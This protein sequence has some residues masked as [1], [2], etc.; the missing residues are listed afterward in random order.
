MA[1]G[2]VLVADDDAAIRVVLNQA[3]SRAG[4]EVRVTSNVSTLWQWVQEG[5]GDCVIS[6]VIMPDGDAFEFMPGIRRERPDLPVIL[7]SAQNTFMTAVK[8]Q[9]AGAYEY[10]PKP[11]DLDELITVTSRAIA[12]PK[13]NRSTQRPE[14]YA[15][16]MPL[17]GRSS[18]MQD[19]YRSI[20]RMMHSDL[21][22]MITGDSG[23]GK[24]L[25]ARVLHDFGNRKHG[26]FVSVNL[27]ALPE[28]VIENEIFGLDS[29]NLSLGLGLL[30][31]ANGGTLY[32]DEV[33][34]LSLSAQ[35]RLLR[36]LLQGDTIP[37][38]GT[39]PVRIDVRIIA[40]TTK[41]MDALIQNGS[42]REDLFYRLNVVPLRLPPLKLRNDDIPD[43][44]RHFLKIM[45]MEG[46]QARHIDGDALKLLKD[47]QWPGNIRELEN[48]IR[49]ICVLYPQE[50][51]TA[52]LVST[53]IRNSGYF[54]QG[55]DGASSSGFNGLRGA[56]EYFVNR[57]FDEHHGMMPPDGVY[58]RFLEDFE[59]PLISSTLAATNGNQIKAA[60]VLGLNRNT[61]RKK[62]QNY[63]IR[64]VKTA[65]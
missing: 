47:H 62:I 6:D 22:V 32:L 63:G 14:D 65:K 17:V 51:I 15:S 58:Q 8:A 53:E 38:G 61:L 57:Y 23:T 52:G 16:G 54:R 29:E 2:I 34:N 50:T 18:V 7:I 9:E 25:T 45:E 10:L 12:E 42:F 44:A 35:A 56:T 48:L 20:A 59:Y 46:A 37:V 11:F 27:T 55:V 21:S 4:F 41:D 40:S 60:Q 3:L 49:R 24:R 30:G 31:R 43:L 13:N 33:G 28:E 64:I 5:E 19:I 1:K 39:T 36:V 26:N